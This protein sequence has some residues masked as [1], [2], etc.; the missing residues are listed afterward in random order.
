MFKLI[1]LEVIGIGICILSL[2]IA[3]IYFDLVKELAACTL[4]VLDRFLVFG[5]S[6]IFLLSIISKRKYFIKTLFSINLILCI[7]GLISTIRHIWLQKFQDKSA[8]DGFGCGGDFFYYIS[9]LPFFEAVRN[10]FDNPTPCNDI[11]WEFLGLSIPMYTFI[12][13]VILTIITI[14]ILIK[15]KN[16]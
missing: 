12:L 16:A 9:T 2:L 11:K 6:F 3:Y 10:I 1:K 7:I 8:I 13:F 15:G 5:I 14:K 4:C